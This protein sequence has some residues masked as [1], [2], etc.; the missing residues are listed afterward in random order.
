VAAVEGTRLTAS[1]VPKQTSRQTSGQA[2]ML[3]AVLA[4]GL[5]ASKVPGQTSRQATA[6]AVQ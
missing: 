2:A 4:V 6:L 5:T 1:E 3:V